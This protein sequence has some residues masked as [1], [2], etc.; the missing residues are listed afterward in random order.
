MSN[1][2]KTPSHCNHCNSV[3]I[4]FNIWNRL[5]YWS[6]KTCKK[7][8]VYIEPIKDA[9]QWSSWDPRSYGFGSSDFKFTAPVGG[10]YQITLPDGFTFNTEDIIRKDD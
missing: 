4:I 1:E 6:C 5:E 7:E 9:F 2:K 8:V 10:T 3:D